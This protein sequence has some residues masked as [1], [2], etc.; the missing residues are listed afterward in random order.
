MNILSSGLLITDPE[1]YVLFFSEAY[2][3]FLG[4]DPPEKNRQALHRSDREY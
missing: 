4:M 1:G 2:G 3:K